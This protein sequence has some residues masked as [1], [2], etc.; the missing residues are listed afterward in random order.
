MKDTAF[1][2]VDRRRLVAQYADGNLNLDAWPTTMMRTSLED[3]SPFRPFGFLIRLR[4]H[5][6]EPAWPERRAMS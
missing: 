2:V 3:R 1:A 4:F 5:P 6:A